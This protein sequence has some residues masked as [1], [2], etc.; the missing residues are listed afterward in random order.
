LTRSAIT[1]DLLDTPDAR[2][3]RLN[4]L[5]DEATT[6]ESCG[7]LRVGDRVRPLGGSWARKDTFVIVELRS[8]PSPLSGGPDAVAVIQDA[9]DE[10]YVVEVGQICRV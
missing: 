10:T 4:N 1:A 2:S 7:D 8:S 6:P 3:G 9:N 5:S